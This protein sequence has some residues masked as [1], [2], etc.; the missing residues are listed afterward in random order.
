MA[1]RRVTTYALVAVTYERIAEPKLALG[2]LNWA[3]VLVGAADATLLPYV[4]LYLFQRGLGAEQIGAILAAAAAG[5]LFAGMGWAYLADHSIRPERAVVGASVAAAAVILLFPLAGGVF[6][7]AVLTVALFVARGPFTLLDPITLQR[8]REA[9][10]T[11]YARIRLRMSAGWAVSAVISG[12]AYQVFGLRMLPF[13]Y[14]PMVA[15]FGLWVWHALRPAPV[16][17]AQPGAAGTRRLPALPVAMIGFLVACL[18]LGASSAAAQNFVALRINVLGGGALLIGAAAAFQA[19]TEIPTM[20]TTHL[21]IRRM[22]HRSLFAIGCGVYVAVFLAWGLAS[23]PV[24]LALLRLATGVAFALT[25]VAAVLIAD[26]LTPAHM[27]ATG[28]ALVKAVMF[29]LA[30]IAGS[31][32]GGLIY[33]EVGPRAMFIAATIVVAAAGVIAVVGIPSERRPK[34]ADRAP[35]RLESSLVHETAEAREGATLS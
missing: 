28:Q 33:G 22:S 3:Y 13:L 19:L 12:G 15:I 11:R 18:L 26:Q 25:Y 16:Q 6:P 9:S 35:A 29:G 17:R 20:G 14:A 32:G 10:R 24:A 27:R 31:F 21:L 30:P 7:V 2:G 8:L 1:A 4:P 5:S 23:D 34:A